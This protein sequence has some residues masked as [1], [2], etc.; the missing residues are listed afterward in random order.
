MT[1]SLSILPGMGVLI[2]DGEKIVQGKVWQKYSAGVG[3][4]KVI[5]LLDEELQLLLNRC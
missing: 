5:V 3:V 2:V 4:E 1:N